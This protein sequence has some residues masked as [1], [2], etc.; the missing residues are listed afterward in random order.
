MKKI[1]LTAL[2]LSS[3]CLSSFGA[4]SVYA[5]PNGDNSPHVETNATEDTASPYL[6]TKMSI[7]TRADSEYV[8][9]VAKNT[10]TLFI[11]TVP[12]DIYL[13]SSVTYTDDIS[14]MTLEATAHTGDLDVNKEITCKAL[15]T[16]QK[17]WV[18]HCVFKT[19]SKTKTATSYPVLYSVEGKVI[20]N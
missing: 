13:Y 7:K 11:S 18:A 16:E 10:F 3:L 4:V 2:I 15:H 9:A 17:Y 5:S 12:V 8:Y 1:L 6:L 14:Q 20:S 19:D